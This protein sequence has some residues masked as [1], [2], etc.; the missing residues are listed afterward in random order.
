MVPVANFPL[1]GMRGSL[2]S[3]S[4]RDVREITLDLNVEEAAGT[5]SAKFRRDFR[6]LDSELSRIASNYLGIGSTVVK[7]STSNPHALSLCL[8]RFKRSG[9]LVLGTRYRGSSGLGEVQWYGV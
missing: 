9:K 2:G 4:S 5:S 8:R 6:K 3:V 1:D 7:L